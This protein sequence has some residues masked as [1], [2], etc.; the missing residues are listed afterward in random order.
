LAYC[1]TLLLDIDRLAD[2]ARAMR[3]VSYN[4]VNL[5]SFHDRD[6]EARDG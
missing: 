4:R 3:L 1:F 5:F 6:H 2:T